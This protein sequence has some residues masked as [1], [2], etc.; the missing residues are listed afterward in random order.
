MSNAIPFWDRNAAGYE[1]RPVADPDSYQTK[2]EVTRRYLTDTSRV[3][4]VGCGTGSTAIAHAPHA[5]HILATDLSGKMLEFAQQK[6]DD[7]DVRNVEFRQVSI[8]SI[9]EFD[10][11][12]VMAHSLLHLLE[13]KEIAIRKIFRMLKPGG[14]FVSSTICLGETHAWL[15]WIAGPAKLL[16]LFPLIRFFTGDQLRESIT[17]AGFAIEYDWQ[18]GPKKA[19]FLIARRPE[20]PE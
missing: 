10:F 15:R 6:A 9:D 14:V 11:D 18:P 8:E 4:E 12:M 1:K 7:A 20:A 5:G 13:D 19:L 3:L 2:L 16:G 17:S